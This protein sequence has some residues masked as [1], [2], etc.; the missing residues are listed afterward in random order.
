M[1]AQRLIEKI[2]KKDAVVG[3]IGLGYAGLPLA[4]E[5]AEIGFTVIGVDLNRERVHSLQNGKSYVEDIPS[6]RLNEQIR[7][8][9]FLPTDNSEELSRA[10]VILICVQT[11]LRKTKD[12]D[13]SFILKAIEGIPSPGSK[14]RLIVLQSTTF[15]GTTQE[16]IKPYFENSGRKVG[17]DFFLVF[18]PERIDPGNTKYHSANIPKIIGGET[19]QCVRVGQVFFEL[20]FEKVIPVSSTRVAEMV[21]LLENTF[22]MVNVAL[23]NEFALMCHKMNL[24][25]W[26]VIDSASTKPFGFMPFYP[27]PGLG[28]HC[29]PVDPLYLSW[30]AKIFNFDP[31]FIDLATSINSRMPEEVVNRIADILN[32]KGQSLKGAHLLMLGVAYKQNIADVRESPAL[33]ILQILREKGGHVSYHDPYISKFDFEG[34]TYTSHKLTANLLKKS[35]M[36]IIVTSHDS[37]D[38]SFILENSKIVFDTRNATKGL[39]SNKCKVVRL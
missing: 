20:V 6:P 35:D 4:V 30:K 5:L 7:D 29:L 25:V 26:E 9:R 36:A 17:K 11:P 14:E 24:D 28:G 19:D 18:A 39:N 3:V 15:P 8:Q 13:I 27:G 22:R 33:D 10:D 23:V 31:R 1:S 38:Y 16:V 21:K 12:P 32:E 34:E 37:F 2:K